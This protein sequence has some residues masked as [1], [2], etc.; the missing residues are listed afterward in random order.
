MTNPNSTEKVIVFIDAEYVIQSLR[1]LR[2]KPRQN[3]IGIHNILWKNIIDFVVERRTLKEVFYYSSELDK[4]ENPDTYQK[5]KEYLDK[6]RKDI[7][8]VVVIRLGKMQ[9][10]RIKA[11]KTWTENSKV[12]HDNI[13]TW[14]QKGIDVK[15]AID[16]LIKAFKSEYET[17]ILIAGDCDFEEVIKEVRGLNKKVELVTFDRFDAKVIDSFAHSADR[18]TIIDYKMGTDTFWTEFVSR[19]K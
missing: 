1:T 7:G 5:Q 11:E 15:L 10:V 2:G 4:D 9:K 14:V 6:V 12:T 19:Q 8:G 3:R 17:A 13:H 16:M 18:H